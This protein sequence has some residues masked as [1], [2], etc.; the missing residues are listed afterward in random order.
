MMS[1][2]VLGTKTRRIWYDLIMKLM[3]I[4]SG[5][6]GVAFMGTSGTR[7]GTN[8]YGRAR[9]GTIVLRIVRLYYGLYDCITDEM[10]ADDILLF[11]TNACGCSCL[12]V[13]IEANDIL[14]LITNDACGC[15]CFFG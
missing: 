12:L 11:I 1:P 7:T 2:H 10:Q 13:E 15:S 14:L 3:N 8:V 9:T 5:L 4:S 6:C